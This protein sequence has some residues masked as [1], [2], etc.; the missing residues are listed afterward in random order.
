M[1]TFDSCR[2]KHGFG[3]AALTSAV[4]I[5]HASTAGGCELAEFAAIAYRGLLPLKHLYRL[6]C[7]AD[8]RH[9]GVNTLFNV[10]ELTA[11]AKLICESE[12]AIGIKRSHSGYAFN[13]QIVVSCA[14]NVIKLSSFCFSFTNLVL[15]LAKHPKQT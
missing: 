14:T 6:A 11:N 8:G 10:R 12:V 13:R 2:N 9:F 5:S 7:G 3:L 15:L 4:L 1:L